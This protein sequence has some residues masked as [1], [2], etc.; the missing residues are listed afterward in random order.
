MIR[1]LLK[2]RK[3][4]SDLDLDKSKENPNEGKCGRFTGNLLDLSKFYLRQRTEYVCTG[5]TCERSR[6]RGHP[7]CQRTSLLE[8]GLWGRLASLAS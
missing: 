8:T 3:H 7:C 1:D 5:A 4:T 2:N 6:S